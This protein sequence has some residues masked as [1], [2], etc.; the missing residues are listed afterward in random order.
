M[1][2]VCIGAGATVVILGTSA[3]IGS[4][5]GIKPPQTRIQKAISVIGSL[6]LAAITSIAIKLL[7]NVSVFGGHGLSLLGISFMVLW[8]TPMAIIYSVGINLL[9]DRYA[10]EHGHSG[11]KS[12]C[13]S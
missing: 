3:V 1:C 11:T 13:K 5:F 12:C 8:T 7:F 4:A 6:C 9:L 10:T 2:G